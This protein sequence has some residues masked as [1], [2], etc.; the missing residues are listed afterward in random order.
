VCD[1]TI[2]FLRQPDDIKI[3]PFRQGDGGIFAIAHELSE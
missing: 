1:T 2:S 3:S